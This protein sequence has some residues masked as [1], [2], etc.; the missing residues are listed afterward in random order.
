MARSGIAGM[1]LR[2][3]PAAVEAYAT[4]RVA[5]RN[6]PA[7]RCDLQHSPNDGGAVF[8]SV[9][10]K[11]PSREVHHTI[12]EADLRPNFQSLGESD[13]HIDVFERRQDHGGGIGK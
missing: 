12:A 4:A 1:V 9:C 2:P 10:P 11:S 6:W 7:A 8:R 13:R 3:L 5:E